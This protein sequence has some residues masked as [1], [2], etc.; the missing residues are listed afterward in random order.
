MRVIEFC[1]QQSFS[2]TIKYL[3]QLM[4]EQHNIQYNTVIVR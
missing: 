1:S 3:E 4:S 2:F